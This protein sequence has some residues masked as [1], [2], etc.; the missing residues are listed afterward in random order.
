M[1]ILKKGTKLYSILHLKCPRCQEGDL[2]PTPTFS[3]KK[4]FD[5]PETCPHC[6]QRYFLEPG[7][8]YGAMFISYLITGF[9]SLAFI[10][11]MMFGFGLSVDVSFLFLVVV[12]ALLFV[13]FFRVARAIWI[14]VNV[15]YSGQ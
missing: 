8:Y 10:G 6:G 5:M 9:F 13:W 15:K 12:M 7:F 1:A 4:S 11:G 3:F 14:N 2:F